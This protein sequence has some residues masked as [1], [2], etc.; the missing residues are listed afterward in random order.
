[1]L[2][3]HSV[4]SA[5][6]RGFDNFIDG[7]FIDRNLNRRDI[8]GRNIGCGEF[9]NNRFGC[10]RYVILGRWLRRGFYFFAEFGECGLIAGQS[11]EL[12][13]SRHRLCG[14]PMSKIETNFVNGLV[15][16]A[17]DVHFTTRGGAGDLGFSRFRRRSIGVNSDGVVPLGGE[18]DFSGR[19]DR[20]S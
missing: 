20:V 13:E 11:L 8:D 3:N 19:C 7:R 1:M 9:F 14:H 4:R 18:I 10:N 12:G 6:D 2:V 15:G 17:G 5:C 16:F